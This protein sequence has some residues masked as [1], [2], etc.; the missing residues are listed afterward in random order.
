MKKVNILFLMLAVCVSLC[1]QEV[2]KNSELAISKLEK[3]VYVVETSD[4]TTM[5]IIEGRDRAALIDTGTKCEALDSIVALITQKPLLVIATHAHGDHIGNIRYFREIYIHPADSVLMKAANYKGVVHDLHAGQVIDLGGKQLEIDLLPGHTPGSIVLFDKADGI[6][7]TG[8]AFG[9]GQVWMQLQ[10]HVPMTTYHTSCRRMLKWMDG[11]IGKI[12]CGHYPYLKRALGR[13]YMER[14]TSLAKRLSEG[15]TEGSA[16]AMNIN[17]R[18][19]GK[20]PMLLADG[21][22]V[23]VFDPDNI[24]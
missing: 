22:A 12:Y 24:N 23:I 18:P 13:D 5:Y 19:G 21:D 14:M 16:T 10:P 7:Y 11:G 9:S 1:G 2:F 20:R 3:D 17:V 8:D 6:A 4:M 15:N